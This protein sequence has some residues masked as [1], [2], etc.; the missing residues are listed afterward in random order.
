MQKS[1]TSI[2]WCIDYCCCLKHLHEGIY[3]GLGGAGNERQVQDALPISTKQHIPPMNGRWELLWHPLQQPTDSPNRPSTPLKQSVITGTSQNTGGGHYLPSVPPCTL[4]MHTARVP[5]LQIDPSLH[6]LTCKFSQVAHVHFIS[7]TPHSGI[8]HLRQD[9]PIVFGH[10]MAI[11]A[12]L[13]DHLAER[14]SQ[15]RIT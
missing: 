2:L 10:G 9:K 14:Y 15:Y 11:S 13:P 12:L 1:P 4:I 6:L 5:A 8:P 7:Q 3:G